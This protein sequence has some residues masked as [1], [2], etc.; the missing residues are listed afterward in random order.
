MSA[1]LIQ[2]HRAI[3]DGDRA[4]ARQILNEYHANHADS[5]EE[6]QWLLAHAED[7]Y[8][9]FMQGLYQ[10]IEEGD[11]ENRYVTMAQ[12]YINEEHELRAKVTPPPRRSR[13]KLFVGSGIIAV[14]LLGIWII[15]LGFFSNQSSTINDIATE[16]SNIMQEEIATP[17]LVDRSQV[18]FGDTYTARF[19]SGI[20]QIMAVEDRSG[21][22]RYSRDDSLATPVPGARFVAISILFECRDGIC[23]EPP[24][25]DL[26][27][28]LDGL[29]LTA[30]RADLYISDVLDLEPVAL[31]RATE[32]WI[33]F[34]VPV[35]NRPTSLVIR[36]L[37]NDFG[38]R[39]PD[40]VIDLPIF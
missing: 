19:T 15:Y 2:A 27:L 10:L 22:V 34:E 6:L 21:R 7:D 36:P 18:L 20:I 24:Q 13:S 39:S 25:A 26:F 1:L 40:I 31:G 4:E 33:I 29:E 3:F 12:E 14:I 17:G 32:G 23:R 5:N 16:D 11:S 8:D 30:N 28:E 35:L 9:L 37:A 38:T